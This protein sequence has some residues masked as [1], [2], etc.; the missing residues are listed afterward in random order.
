MSGRAHLSPSLELHRLFPRHCSPGGRSQSCQKKKKAL[1]NGE[2]CGRSWGEMEGEG[3][4]I[5]VCCFLKSSGMMIAQK[6]E[7]NENPCLRNTC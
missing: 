1:D 6:L 7:D 4:G 5:F 2:A 3:N